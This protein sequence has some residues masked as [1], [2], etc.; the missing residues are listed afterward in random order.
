MTN[1]L[2]G[3]RGQAYYSRLKAILAEC[4]QQMALDAHNIKRDTGKFTVVDI[5]RLARRYEL[6]YKATCEWLE[7]SGVLRTGTYDYILDGGIRVRDIMAALDAQDALE[8][9]QGA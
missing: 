1:Q 5:G 7:E 4:G 6:N 3:L 9:P 8:S 2:Q